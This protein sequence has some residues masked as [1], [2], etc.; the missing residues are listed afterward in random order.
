MSVKGPA[1]L[2]DR[3]GRQVTY[4]RM[5]VTDRCDFRCVYCM[6]E[7]M[8]FLP[9]SEVLSLEELYDIGAA[10]VR[11]GVNKIRLTGGEPLVRRDV[12]SLIE[13]LG[14]LPIELVMT[15]NGSQLPGMAQDLVNAGMRRINISLDSLRAARFSELTRTGKLDKVLS[16]IEAAKSAGFKRIKLNAVVLK[17]RNDDEVLDLVDF[18]RRGGLDITF[19][20]EMPLGQ[21]SEHGRAESYCSSD[22]L[23]ELI[24]SRY[25][26]LDSTEN[27]GGPSRYFRMADSASRIGFISPHSHNFCGDCN[28]VRLTVEGMLLLCLGNEHSLDLREIVRSYP[29]DADQL[30]AAL[31]R[32]MDIKPEKHEFNLDEEPQILRFMN[33]TG[34]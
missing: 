7:D 14:Q 17:G 24:G 27:T 15:T 3:F 6:S 30:E 1:P 12:L 32:A 29:G 16:G 13:R 22:E 9:R 26:L 11:L 28:R 19:I 18:A 20:E 23:R 34:G 8:K 25:S 10:F 33:M 4:L 2:I 31:R 5:S 21:I